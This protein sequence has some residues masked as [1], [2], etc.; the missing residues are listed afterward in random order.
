MWD[1]QKVH[2]LNVFRAY[3]GIRSYIDS[4]KEVPKIPKRMTDIVK[5]QNYVFNKRRLSGKCIT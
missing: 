2:E 5:L 4:V 3:I 1:I